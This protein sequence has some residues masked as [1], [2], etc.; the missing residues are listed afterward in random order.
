[1]SSIEKKAR[2]L[3]AENFSTTLIN[4]LMALVVMQIAVITLW[5][6]LADDA[7]GDAGRDAQILAMQGIG[8]RT[9]GSLRAAFDQ[10]GAYNQWVELD[11]LARVAEQRGDDAAAARLRAARDRVAKLSPA[12]QPP[13]FDPAHDVKPNLAALQADHFVR[14][15]YTLQEQFEN[16]QRLKAQYSNQA[17]AYAVQLTMLAVALFVFG[18]AAGNKRRVRVVFIALGAG[19][20]LV[21]LVWMLWTYFTPIHSLPDDAIDAYAAGSAALYQGETEQ[22]LADYD[23]ALERA[24]RYLNA[25]RERAYTKYLLGDYAGSASDFESARANGDTSIDALGNLGFLYYLLGDWA[26][27]HA[28]NETAA[29]RAPNE[30]WIQ[31]NYALGLLA[32]GQTERAQTVYFDA[33]QNAAQRVAAARANNQEPPD[34]LWIEF[35]E[36][37]LDLEALRACAAEQR[38]EDAPPASALRNPATISTLAAQWTTQLKEHAVAL[39]YTSQPPPATTNAQVDEFLFTREFS[40]DDEPINEADTFT[41]TDEPIY[42]LIP[43]RNFVDGQQIVIKVYVDGIEDDR[44]RLADDFSSEEMGGADGDIFLEITTGGVPLDAG[45]YRVEMFVDSKLVGT[46]EFQVLEE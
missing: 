1:M 37:A 36:G 25:Y 35:D 46:G 33:L 26:Q 24:P 13:Y 41:A 31:F 20:S 17:S 23:R 27:A 12:L 18:I 7:N 44:L 39:E 43:F 38:C 10:T 34:G 4:V 21:V 16:Q 32:D 14:A 2:P 42:V 15:S 11:T 22:A 8:K 45:A 6:T 9:V 30:L 40:E 28:F 29:A 3:F 5:F 19:L